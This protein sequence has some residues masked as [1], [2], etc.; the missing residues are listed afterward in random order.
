VSIGSQVSSVL[1]KPVSA[2]C[3]LA[4]KYCFYSAKAALYPETSQHRMNKDVLRELVS[5]LMSLSLERVSFCW[6][7]G[8][9]TLA[10]LE[11]FKQAVKFHS[12]FRIPGQ[13]VE[14]SLQTNGVLID[15]EWAGFLSRHRFLVGVSL[16]GPAEFHNRYRKDHSNGSSY[17]RVIRGIERL[18]S[19]NVDFNILVLLNDT[20]IRRPRKLFRFFLDQGFRYLQFI[21]CVERSPETGEIAQ[22]SITPEQYG[23]FL[24]EAFDEWA[25]KGVPKVY[26]RDFEDLLISY[27]TGEAASCVFSRD[28]G[29]YVVVEHNGDVFPCDFFVD[30]ELLLGNIMESSL[31]E[32][33]ENPKFAEFSMQKR[34]LV[35][36]CKGCSWPKYCNGGCPKHWIQ[37]GI[38]HNYFCESYRMLFKHAHDRFLELKAYVEHK[39]K[40]MIE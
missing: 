29:K 32:I 16:D 21:P 20:N 38:D 37:L 30:P 33:V 14:N 34:R 23:R 10:G 12:L 1:V 18:R 40:G 17:E 3:N 15:E 2:D 11:F 25:G 27:V 8:E 4:C 13:I 28:C 31:E 19:Y 36:K 7:G 6:Q 9:P 22:Y 26:V 35:T 24:C 39:R 5:Q